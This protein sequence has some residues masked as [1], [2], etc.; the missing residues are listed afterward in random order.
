VKG[1]EKCA[2][3]TCYDPPRSSKS[4]FCRACAAWL[5]VWEERTP[6][7]V[8]RRVGQIHRLASRADEMPL[9][10]MRKRRAS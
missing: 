7:E 9:P 2:T 8:E 1:K 6:E 3:S 4:M 10:G 5:H